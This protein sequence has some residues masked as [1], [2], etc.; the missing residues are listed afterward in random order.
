M[1]ENFDWKFYLEYYKDIT[2]PC[3]TKNQYR[4]FKHYQK[5]GRFNHGQSIFGLPKSLPR[6]Q[7]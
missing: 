6:S 3:L 7:L 5:F 1:S 4:C 2:R